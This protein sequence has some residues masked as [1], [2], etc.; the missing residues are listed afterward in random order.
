MTTSSDRIDAAASL[1]ASARLPGEPIATPP[2]EL[3]PVDDAEAWAIHQALV[4]RRGPLAGWKVGA[5]SPTAGPGV[6][7]ISADTL[8]RGRTEIPFS[9]FRLWAVEAEI[10]VTF[11]RDLAPR[12]NLYEAADVL[13]AVGSWHAAIEVLDTAFADWRGAPSL[14]KVADRQNHG[15]LIIGAGSDRAPHGP[16]GEVPVRLLIDGAPVFAH[17]GGN[18]AGDP[19]WLLVALANR[20]AGT[21]RW[22][23]AGDV[24]TTGSTT[25]FL[26]AKPGQRVTA[27]FEGLAPAELVVGA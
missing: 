24:V 9:A 12:G 3:A 16:L 13:G 26:Q 21:E 5:A 6:G 27:E 20:L 19:T 2:A 22:I 23:R 18:S 11:A 10:A 14:W 25:K 7:E 17:R 1:L 4:A 15:A 8:F